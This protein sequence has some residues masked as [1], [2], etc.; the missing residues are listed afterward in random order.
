MHNY[1]F[2]NPFRPK[3]TILLFLELQTLRKCKLHPFI[4]VEWGPNAD[5]ALTNLE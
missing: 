1:F 5:A 2:L 3:N 4:V